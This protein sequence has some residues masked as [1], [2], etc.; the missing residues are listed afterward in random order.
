MQ[1]KWRQDKEQYYWVCTPSC[2]GR[3]RVSITKGSFFYNR[4]ADLRLVF[5]VV[6]AFVLQHS[7]GAIMRE[8]NMMHQ[9]LAQIL[10]DL[11]MLIKED[12]TENDL[13]LGGIDE[14]G[15]RIIV[16]IDEA[17][18][19]KTKVTRGRHGH[20]VEG[21]CVFG[22]VQRTGRRRCFCRILRA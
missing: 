4:K 17:K 16:E 19:G 13:L 18:F 5:F 8:T 9:T 7:M 6:R 22:M 3:T 10:R 15:D 1:L 11:Y 21:V 2:C 14:N 20:P 12:L